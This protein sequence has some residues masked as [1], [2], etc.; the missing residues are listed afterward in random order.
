MQKSHVSREGEKKPIT[1]TKG[2]Q[3]HYHRL[4]LA[5]TEVNQTGAGSWPSFNKHDVLNIENQPEKKKDGCAIADAVYVVVVIHVG[6]DGV[7]EARMK[8][9]GLVEDEE[10]LRAA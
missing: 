3:T 1:G 9:L 2:T 10:G 7:N 5:E 6:F 8:F 4:T